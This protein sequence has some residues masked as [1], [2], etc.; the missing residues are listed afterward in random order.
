MYAVGPGVRCCWFTAS[1]ARVEHCG[2]FPQWDVPAQT[3]RLILQ[4]T[5]QEANVTPIRAGQ[6]HPASAA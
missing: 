3:S 6:S 1:E 2:H 5:G 4:S